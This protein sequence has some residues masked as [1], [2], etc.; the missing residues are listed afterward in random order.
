MLEQ[1]AA[2]L[3]EHSDIVCQSHAGATAEYRPCTVYRQ[4]AEKPFCASDTL[5][6]HKKPKGQQQSSI[7]G[8]AYDVTGRVEDASTE[9]VSFARTSDGNLQRWLGRKA[10]L[11]DA[12]VTVAW[13]TRFGSYYSRLGP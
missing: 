7:P 8:V 11:H 9:K 4:G 6:Q 3:P 12:V 1:R 5:Q 10:G 13:L 2:F